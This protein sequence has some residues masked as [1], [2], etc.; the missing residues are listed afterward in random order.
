M[1]AADTELET[2]VGFG[3]IAALITFLGAWGYCAVTYGFLL[4]FGLGWLPAAI[5]AAIAG[6]VVAL[7]WT[8]RV[9]LLWFAAMVLAVAAIV[10]AVIFSAWHKLHR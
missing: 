5:A 3:V 7:L 9:A 1:N 10:A 4:G 8:F 2:A 6:A